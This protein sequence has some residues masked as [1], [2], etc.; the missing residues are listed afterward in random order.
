MSGVL[1]NLSTPKIKRDRSASENNE[2][3][4][5]N[6]DRQPPV[7]NDDDNDNEAEDDDKYDDDNDPGVS[8]DKNLRP[9]ELRLTSKTFTRLERF[10][11]EAIPYSIPQSIGYELEMRLAPMEEIK[12]AAVIRRT[13]NSDARTLIRGMKQGT[14]IVKIFEVTFQQASV[15]EKAHSW[16]SMVSAISR[17]QKSS[18][19]QLY[20]DFIA[21]LY[22]KTIEMKDSNTLKKTDKRYSVH[23][24]QQGPD[25]NQRKSEKA[26][27]NLSEG[28]SNARIGSKNKDR[29]TC[30]DS[31]LSLLKNKYPVVTKNEPAFL[32]S[33]V[34]SL[35]VFQDTV[36]LYEEELEKRQKQY[37]FSMNAAN[38]AQQ[39]LNTEQWSRIADRWLYNT[40]ADV[41]A[42][43]FRENL[44]SETIVQIKSGK[45]PDEN[46]NSRINE[47]LELV[48]N[49]EFQAECKSCVKGSVFEMSN[50][51]MRR[52]I[53]W[54]RRLCH[55][56]ADRLKWTISHTV[57]LDLDLSD[58]KSL[59]SEACEMGRSLKYTTRDHTPRMG[60]IGEDVSLYRIFKAL[61]HKNEA[62][63]ELKAI[64]SK[65]NIRLRQNH[66]LRVKRIT[67]EGGRNWGLG[68]FQEFADKQEIDIIISSPDNHYQNGVP[69]RGIRFLQDA[70]RCCSIQMKV[71]S[72]F[73]DCMLDDMLHV[74][75]YIS[76]LLKSQENS[77]GDV[78]A[79]YGSKYNITES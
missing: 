46:K 15:R 74:E 27:K 29:S 56:S 3:L 63:A 51:I 60:N 75:F 9:K 21:H 64:L 50:E 31:S 48:E 33:T 42:T 22:H 45:F 32:Y 16:H 30:V 73:W 54:S 36:N 35:S 7:Q 20:Q 6:I 4:P 40:G 68:T 55:P 65:A 24:I 18:L 72:V 59:P 67:T 58:I 37:S 26:L 13:T 44:I 5:P 57:G 62:V 76:G 8:W 70:A 52:L 39:V 2:S 17:F 1:K 53:L 10:C 12:L 49:Q 43:N 77:L 23:S 47:N 38:V 19:E 66:G 11:I 79:F 41:H 34:V 78:L 14:K 25:G 28:M 71:P 61:K 69:E